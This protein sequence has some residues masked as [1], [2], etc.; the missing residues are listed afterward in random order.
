[1]T[2]F[3]HDKPVSQLS[4][5]RL[6]QQGYALPDR[7]P[8]PLPEGQLLLTPHTF[9]HDALVLEGHQA[10]RVVLHDKY[11]RPFLDVSFDAPVFGLW[12]PV[13]APFCCIE[14]WYGRTDAEGFA[15]TISERQ[16]IQR[17]DAHKSFIFKYNINIL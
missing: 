17:L 15:G 16:H 12:S 3:L 2:F 11:C 1:M 9:R 8:M 6:S 10:D 5:T 13:G 7:L 4:V 14:P